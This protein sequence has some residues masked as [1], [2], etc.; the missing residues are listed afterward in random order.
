MSPHIKIAAE[1]LRQLLREGRTVAIPTVGASMRPLLTPGG[2]IRVAH[3][4]ADGVRP[5]DVVVVSSDDALICHRL[6]YVEDGR[7]VT[8]GDDCPDSDPPLP[9]DAIIG[10]VDIPPS[11]HA[12]YCAVRALLRPLA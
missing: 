9:A 11:P 6:L 10:R 4:T 1:T 2:V 8:R 7:M 3:T 5:G 12:L